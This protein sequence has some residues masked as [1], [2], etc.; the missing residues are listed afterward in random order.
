MGVLQWL[1]FLLLL[2]EARG[3]SGDSG[4]SGDGENP[5]DI[6]GVLQE[7]ICFPLEIPS[8]EEVR[9][10]ILSSHTTL[11]TIVPGTKEPGNNITVTNW[12]YQGRVGLLDHS[13]SLCISNLSLADSGPYQV[14]VHLKTSLFLNEQNYDLRVYRR[15]SEPQVSLKFKLSGEG[16][17]NVSLACSVEVSHDVIYSWMSLEGGTTTHNGS[18]LSTSWRPG[19]KALS[20]AC[21]AT[22]PVG[23]ISSRPIPVGTFC[24][25]LSH[26]SQKT[27]GHFCILVKGLLL[28][29]LLGSLAVGLWLS[30]SRMRHEVLEMRKLRRNRMKLK[31]KD[32]TGPSLP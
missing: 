7:S 6:V 10:I 3:D 12:R 29:M 19:D 22:N 13:C 1:L 17:C 8:N 32:K 14:Q 2:Q 30:R 27:E 4:D 23:S 31:K 24:A 20:Y 16:S 5:K 18:V 9:S 28:L 26:P 21:R 25:D 15:L 11:A